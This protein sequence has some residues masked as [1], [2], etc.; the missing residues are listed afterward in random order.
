MIAVDDIHAQL[1]AVT[2]VLVRRLDE[3][4]V[5][6]VES[7]GTY[8]IAYEMLEQYFQ[9]RTTTFERSDLECC[10]ELDVRSETVNKRFEPLET[11]GFITICRDGRQNEYMLNEP[12]AQWLDDSLPTDLPA[13]YS[14]G[15]NALVPTVTDDPDP[16]V[17]IGPLALPEPTPERLTTYQGEWATKAVFCFLIGP[18]IVYS[19]VS[20][21][22]WIAL[23]LTVLGFWYASL[24]LSVSGVRK[25]QLLR[26]SPRMPIR[27]LLAR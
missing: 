13:K 8:R 9:D 3:Q 22:L 17:A 12:P 7:P 25:L 26:S 19:G 18:F 14:P 11:V 1:L 16:G 2:P 23:L 21:G 6:L 27:S 10:R 15:P 24:T 4:G 5:S 20:L